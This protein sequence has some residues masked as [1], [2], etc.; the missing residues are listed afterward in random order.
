[1][2]SDTA[3]PTQ[4]GSIATAT[5]AL[6]ELPASLPPNVV[7]VV[8]LVDRLG[9]QAEESRRSVEAMQAIARRSGWVAHSSRFWLEWG[10]RDL[11]R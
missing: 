11:T 4:H 10:P 3:H 9:E 8:A 2:R 5:R 7:W 1:M 6:E